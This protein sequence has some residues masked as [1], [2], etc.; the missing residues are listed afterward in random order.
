MSGLEFISHLAAHMV[1]CFGLV[2]RT[3][4]KRQ[5]YFMVFTE[6]CLQNIKNS[7][8]PLTVPVSQLRIRKRLGWGTA[9]VN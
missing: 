3:V 1:L 7:P 4:L 2:S 9:D 6:Y 8:V 5:Q